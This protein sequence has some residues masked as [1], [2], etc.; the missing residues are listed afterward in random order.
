M[1]EI[2]S[3]KG[4]NPVKSSFSSDNFIQAA[5]FDSASDLAK[6]RMRCK[7]FYFSFLDTSMGCCFPVALHLL[8]VQEATP[9]LARSSLIWQ[10]M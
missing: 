6:K 7:E 9:K 1:S 10:L 5:Q 2:N 3:K 8:L 4:E